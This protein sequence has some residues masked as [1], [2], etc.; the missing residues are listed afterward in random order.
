MYLVMLNSQ[1]KELFLGLAYAIA[2]SDGTYSDVEKKMINAYC[3]EMQIDFKEDSM[4]KP[5]EDIILTFTKV[6]SEEIKKIVVFEAIGIAMVDG[7]YD[8]NE[9]KIIIEM[10][11]KF[12]LEAGFNKKC[13]SLLNEYISIQHRMNQ[14][15]IG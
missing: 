13:E 15:I 8:E 5:V 7:G 6:S 9:R 1:E 3:Q 4:I 2:S 14:L 12:K 11:E 10:E